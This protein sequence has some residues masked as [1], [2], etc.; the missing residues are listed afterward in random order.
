MPTHRIGTIVAAGL[1][2]GLMAGCGS[3]HSQAITPPASV[4]PP[5]AVTSPGSVTSPTSVTPPGSVPSPTQVSGGT[6]H[7]GTN[8]PPKTGTVA[9]SML[10]AYQAIS[11]NPAPS[12]PIQTVLDPANSRETW[13]LVPVGIQEPRNTTT[14]L[15]FGVQRTPHGPWQ[16]IPSTL[17]AML[18]S[19]LPLPAHQALQLA[20]DWHDGQTGPDN[21]PGHVSWSALTG[22]VTEPVGWSMETLSAQ[23]SP[24]ATATV[25]I[26]VFQAPYGGPF[27][28]LYGMVT[29]WDAHNTPTGTHALDGIWTTTEPLSHAVHR[30]F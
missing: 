18:S 8:N 2:T 16:W 1:L 9:K 12:V 19:A 22:L 24:L 6:R 5:G 29:D 30:T 25:Q 4:T 28:G 15:W 26:T 27:H 13:A 3:T 21:L 14:T 11:H 20:F 7:F 17:P 23:D 10:A